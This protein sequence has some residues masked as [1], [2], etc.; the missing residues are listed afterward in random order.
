MSETF[1]IIPPSDPRSGIPHL[2]PFA[3]AEKA[4]AYAAREGLENPDIQPL[5]DPTVR[6]TAPATREVSALAGEAVRLEP[7]S[8]IQAVRVFRELCSERLGGDL[9]L[10]ASLW[11]IEGAYRQLRRHDEESIARLAQLASNAY[12]EHRLS[13]GDT[14][15]IIELQCMSRAVTP[16]LGRVS[17]EDARKLITTAEEAYKSGREK[18]YGP[19]RSQKH[20][21]SA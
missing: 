12:F 21:S 15:A 16:C 10:S 19:T 17:Y 2:G 14:N 7:N 13:L 20:T 8:R 6:L 18:Q 5:T 1:I 11:H 9:G 3:T 4:A